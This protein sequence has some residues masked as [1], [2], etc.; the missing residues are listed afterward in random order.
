MA[1][2]KD[3]DRAELASYPESSHA[4]SF[5]LYFFD[6]SS[7]TL[8]A[9]SSGEQKQVE[10]KRGGGNKLSLS[11][12]LYLKSSITFAAQSLGVL[13]YISK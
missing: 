6:K 5:V 10:D 1:E 4:H 13:Y 11:F 7:I 12:S 9:Q 3:V 2:L 8:A